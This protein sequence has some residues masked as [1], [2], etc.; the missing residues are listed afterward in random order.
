[1]LTVVSRWTSTLVLLLCACSSSELPLPS[2]VSVSPASMAANERIQLIIE[3]E[4]AL[5]LKVDYGEDS[6]AMSTSA[7]VTIGEQELQ[8]LGTEQGGRRLIAEVAPGLPLGSQDL[9]VV[10]EDG[11]E[12]VLERGF[13]VTQ[14]L[15]ITDFSID[16]VLTQ[17]RLRPF[18][19][20]IR[21]RGPDAE[22]FKGPV[23]LSTSKGE[24]IPTRSGAFNAGLCVQEVRIDDT[25][26]ANITI[27]VEDFAGRTGMSN[28]FRL[29]P[30][31]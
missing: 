20:N 18:F 27:F 14:P 10:L 23:K 21:V 13:Q 22:L 29:N 26:G 24:I 2:I 17:F 4:G 12:A 7:V 9:R 28:D 25:G 30:A 5:P 8:I 3:L 6:V 19:I 15:N 1:M 31:P 16:P 11:R